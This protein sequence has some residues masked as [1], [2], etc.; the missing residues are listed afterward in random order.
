MTDM[1]QAKDKLRKAQLG[2]IDAYL[3]TIRKSYDSLPDTKLEEVRHGLERVV[4]IIEGKEKLPITLDEPFNPKEAKKIRKEYMLSQ[5]ELGEKL[6]FSVQHISR[7]ERGET[8]PSLR[9]GSCGRAYLEF[10]KERGYNP[11]EL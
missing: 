2:V 11:F 9:K 4:K 10:L 3:D 5:R 6:G 7:F 1:Q 8:L